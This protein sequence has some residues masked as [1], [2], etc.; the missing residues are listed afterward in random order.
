MRNLVELMFEF[1]YVKV[2]FKVFGLSVLTLIFVEGRSDLGDCVRK[3]VGGLGFGTIWSVLKDAL[4]RWSVLGTS[5][6]RIYR[7]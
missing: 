4:V 6:V 1:I 3:F 5:L 7:F 2:G